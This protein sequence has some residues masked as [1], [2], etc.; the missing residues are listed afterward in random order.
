MSD[1]DI[2]GPVTAYATGQVTLVKL[3]EQIAEVISKHPSLATEPRLQ[4]IRDKFAT[5]EDEERFDA[6][7][8]DLMFWC[9]YN[10]CKLIHPG[11]K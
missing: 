1:I 5:V 11:A 9:S 7:L 10:G 8:T 6:F 2:T 4:R 3:G